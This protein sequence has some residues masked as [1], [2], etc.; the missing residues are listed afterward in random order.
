MARK[1][2]L[3]AFAVILLLI[4][5]VRFLV[6]GSIS[7]F[8]ATCP[9]G[10]M[11]D[12]TGKCICPVIGFYTDN[13]GNCLPVKAKPAPTESGQDNSPIIIIG[14]FASVFVLIVLFLFIKLGLRGWRTTI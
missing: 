7:G 2:L 6:P 5:L 4:P 11:K 9:N 14:I 8:Q 13:S 10:M 1:N 12:G 3:V